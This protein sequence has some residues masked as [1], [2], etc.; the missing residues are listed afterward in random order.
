MDTRNMDD[1]DER[2]M[3]RPR[4]AGVEIRKSA[5]ATYT[6][7]ALADF[8]AQQMLRVATLPRRGSIR[9]LDPAAGDG[10]LLDALITALP[11]TLRKR[12]QVRG[13]DIDQPALAQAN[14]RL[15]RDHPDV[16]ILLEQADF[17]DVVSRPPNGTPTRRFD[18]V[19]ANP[20]YVRTQI[21]GAQ[22]AQE[23][24]RQ[25][26]LTG[27]VDLYYPFL[28][29][30]SRVLGEDGVAGVIT[31]NRFMST[32]SGQA[33]RREL[34]SRFR[35]TQVWDMGDSKPFGAAVL[36]AVLLARGAKPDGT[37]DAAIGFSSLYET[38]E[39]ATAEAADALS[40]LAAGDDEV[41][42]LA[43]GRRFRVRHGVLD[44]GDTTEGVWRL[45]SVAGEHWLATVAA[46]TWATF[47]HIGKIR[48]GVKSTADKVFIRDDWDGLPDGRPELLRPL[49]T[50]HAARR[51]KADMSP[52]P[53]RRR[54]ILY[55]HVVVNGRREAAD[56]GL[57]PNARAYLERHRD[58]LEARSY[59]IAAGRRWYELWVP[60][61]PAAWSA[62]KL[63]FP[64][65]SEKPVF[66]MDTE[67]GVVNGECYWL[68]CQREHEEDLLWLALAVANSSFI[69]AFYD[70]RFNNKLYAGRRRF[71]TQYVE[72]F[73]LPDPAR[74]ESAEAAALARQ[75]HERLP[76][77]DAERLA[78]EL[79]AR[80]WTLF[81]LAPPAGR[82]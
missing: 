39:P 38:R 55:P 44:H 13:Y 57:C 5:G 22:Q 16:D 34:L 60:Q 23:L 48:V 10:A 53:S 56:L 62:P 45:A 47:R 81:G 20:P 61:D 76:G 29:G 66:W 2:L 12:L 26:G 32:R 6:P 49:I 9:V 51:F 58:T 4:Y 27:R 71:I 59:L 21:M 52:A 75:I 3:R 67:G 64:D 33:V 31:S 42:G 8:V 74:R 28:L 41:A 36:P 68:Q 11:A 1:T 77:D 63:V 70:H 40:A 35:V 82:S 15:R 30:I 80:I 14:E 24:A 46:H 69:E 43:D 37:A 78:R 73:P 54:E 72:Q 7:A 79:D 25:F 18:L 19:I 65:I 50:R 17:L